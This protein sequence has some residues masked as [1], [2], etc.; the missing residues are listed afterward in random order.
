MTSLHQKHRKR[1]HSSDSRSDDSDMETRGVAARAGVQGTWPR[2]LVVEGTS[3]ERPFSSLNP[4]AVEKLFTGIST[5]GFESIRKLRNGSYLVECKTR[6]ASEQLMKKDGESW[7]D[8]P[9][10]V[11][12]HKGLNTSK[13][14]I[15][16][17]GL[18]DCSELEIQKELASQG[19][20]EVKRAHI[21]KKGEKIATNTIFLTFAMAKLPESVKVGYINAKVNPFVP[22]PLRCFRC[23]KFGHTSSNCTAKETCRDCGKE[24][25]EGSCS[26]P[27]HC[28]NCE[29]EHSSTSRECPK[30]KLEVEIQKIKTLERCSF[31]E[32]RTKATALMP[33]TQ[34]Y[35]KAAA[36]PV[37]VERGTEQSVD[38]LV[39][40][41]GVLVERV[42]KLERQLSS[43]LA[44]Q[45]TTPM[46]APSG[47]PTPSPPGKNGPPMPQPRPRVN[48]PPS[49]RATKQPAPSG[50]S[51]PTPPGSD[52]PSPPGTN[53]PS[54]PGTKRT[55]AGQAG[56][57]KGLTKSSTR[58]VSAS[59][60]VD[61]QG[62]AVIRGMGNKNIPVS[63]SKAELPLSNR[64]SSLEDGMETDSHQ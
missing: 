49:P 50:P 5:T 35:A 25:H 6:R 21:T 26:G 56:R 4:F 39:A 52:K 55:P 17:A 40:A 3:T 28:V 63:P 47:A 59:N 9:I 32:A 23:Q 44:K 30:W 48:T 41:I 61:L 16:C 19:V 15:R 8:K 27:T 58:S 45:D 29:G 22:S 54:P 14:V 13:G 10:R 33:T 37:V 18:Q 31:A 1:T 60:L 38:K 51:K 20:L 7:C 12:M 43:F 42:D 11:Y 36:T 34:S 24:K 64:F 2:F 46:P 53:K 62:V 57:G